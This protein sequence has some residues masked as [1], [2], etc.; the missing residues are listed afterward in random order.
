MGHQITDGKRL[1][2]ALTKKVNESVQT[3]KKNG[4][5]IRVAGVV[6]NLMT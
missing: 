1:R 5:R 3:K 4:P 2:Y 6:F